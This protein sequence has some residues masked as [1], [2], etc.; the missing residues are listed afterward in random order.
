VKINIPQSAQA[1]LGRRKVADKQSAAVP[2]KDIER[3]EATE[4][5]ERWSCEVGRR[6][7]RG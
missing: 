5:D 1:G 6:S 2:Q 4:E 7:N 3:N